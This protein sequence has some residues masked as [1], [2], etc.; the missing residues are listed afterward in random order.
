MLLIHR[1]D[2][3]AF[4]V[5]SVI[6]RTEVPGPLGQLIAFQYDQNTK[7][8]E[9]GSKENRQVRVKTCKETCGRRWLE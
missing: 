6:Y 5:V 4:S 3:V 7:F 2:A 8:L 1:S 9:T